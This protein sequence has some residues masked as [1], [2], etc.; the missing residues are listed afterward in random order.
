MYRKQLWE[1]LVKAGLKLPQITKI[2]NVVDTARAETYEEG[3]ITIYACTLN[4]LI[5]DFWPKTAARQIEKLNP[6]VWGTYKELKAHEVTTEDCA[7]YIKKASGIELTGRTIKLRENGNWEK[8]EE[9]GKQARNAN[10]LLARAAE[11]LEK[12]DGNMELIA[13]IRDFLPKK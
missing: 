8:V 5:K 4:S 7:S 9:A 3:A 12:K 11:E 13:Q 1:E 10:L 6:L 2:M